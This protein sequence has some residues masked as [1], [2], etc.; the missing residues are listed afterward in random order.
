[1]AAGKM[2][3]NK[4]KIYISSCSTMKIFNEV[5]AIGITSV[6]YFT[7]I[8]STYKTCNKDPSQIAASA[9]STT[10]CLP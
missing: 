7:G 2:R 1:M 4:A 5:N 6:T 8:P 9:C 10:F 3:I